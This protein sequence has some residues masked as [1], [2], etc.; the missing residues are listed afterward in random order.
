MLNVFVN[1][2][3]SYFS[4]NIGKSTVLDQRKVYIVERSNIVVSFLN[5]EG[6]VYSTLYYVLLPII[7]TSTV[8]T[9]LCTNRSFCTM[10]IRIVNGGNSATKIAPPFDECVI[11][12]LVDHDQVSFIMDVK[13]GSPIYKRLRTD[14]DVSDYIANLL[15]H[16]EIS[17]IK[18]DEENH[19][20]I[21][22]LREL[23]EEPLSDEE[24]GEISTTVPEVIEI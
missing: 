24:I 15:D 21:I 14:E 19:D 9:G 7:N 22:S 18:M 12:S 10:S 20:I 6:V 3:S 2:F 17:S 13:N 5:R 1:H 8:R 11:E 23:G 4:I 16:D